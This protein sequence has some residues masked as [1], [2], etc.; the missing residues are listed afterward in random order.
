MIHHQLCDEFLDD[1]S[2]YRADPE[3]RDLWP[4]EQLELLAEEGVLRDVIP[5]G[6]GGTELAGPQ[7]LARYMALAEADLETTFVLTQRNGACQRLAGCGN[8]ALKAEVLPQLATGERFAT[9]GIS[10]LTTSRQHLAR[11]SVVAERRDGGWSL[12]GQA[13]WVSGAAHADWIVTGGV[14]PGGQQLLALVDPR[15]P[16]A[17]VGRS[18]DLL[19]L[20]SSETA[21]VDLHGVLVADTH[22]LAGP[23]DRVL[24]EAKVG[25]T[26]SLTT[27]ALAAGAAAGSVK[28]ILELA[29][30]RPELESAAR[31]LRQQVQRLQQKILGAAQGQTDGPGESFRLRAEANSLVIRAANAWVAAAK[32]AGYV[33]SH[34]AQRAV[35]EA[36][37]FLV[38]SSPR[39]V[40]L[41]ALDEFAQG[42]GRLQ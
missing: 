36:M 41:Q 28:A 4:A 10:H 17:S 21:S 32:G 14:L 7:L 39:S 18:A 35:R 24:H 37:F 13:P 6:Y 8:E 23:A 33:S 2:S 26:G 5:R 31:R 22:I 34:P 12:S 19:G 1:L 29:V 40:V 30:A 11:P 25:G 3:N 15:T 20:T 42:P 16:L 27:S 9:V 38:W